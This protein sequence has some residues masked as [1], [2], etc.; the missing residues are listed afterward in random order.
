MLLVVKQFILAISMLSLLLQGCKA[1]AA[2]INLADGKSYTFSPEP[3]YSLCTDKEDK[4]QLTDGKTYGSWWVKKSTVGWLWSSTGIE[5]VIDL[6]NGISVDKVRV[7]SVGGGFADVEFPEFIAVLVSDDAQK[8]EFA[9]LIGSDELKDVRSVGHNRVPYTFIIDD[10]GTR[11]RYVK[12]VIR[13][14]GKHFFLDEIEVIGNRGGLYRRQPDARKFRA[15]DSERLL[16]SIED[17]LQARANILETMQRF[18][19]QASRLPRDF[20]KTCRDDLENLL[21]EVRLPADRIFSE[22]EIASIRKR[23]GVVRARIYREIYK[24][25]LVCY[26]TNPMEMVFEKDMP[27]PDIEPDNKVDLRLW[28]NE[29]ESAA[30][31]IM[32]CS[33]KELD[34]TVSVSPLMGGDG[35]VSG[36]AETSTVRRVV[37]VKALGSSRVADALVLQDETPFK[38]SPGWMTQIWYSTA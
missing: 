38:L 26:S 24:K 15:G 9:G 37:F 13:P 18:K 14:E 20:V 29:Y 23:V 8:Y 36:D 25:A 30:V 12:I 21:L 7:H 17:Y 3:N 32:N 19:E 16:K 33:S 31:N 4:S 28:R 22:E 11:A 6:E 10:I 34:L 5:I 35:M 2:D 1:D 27:F